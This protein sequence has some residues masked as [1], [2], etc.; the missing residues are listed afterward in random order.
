MKSF[1]DLYNEFNNDEEINRIG[2]EVLKESSKKRKISLLVC[3]IIAAIDIY[4]LYRLFGNPT[5]NDGIQSIY[6]LVIPTLIINIAAVVFVALIFNK[7]HT[8]FIPIF[9]E[10]VIKKM[11]NNFLDDVKYFPNMGM[12]QDIYKEVKYEYYDRYNSDDY[13]EG[14]LNGKY[15]TELAEIKTEEKKE[16]R[17]EDGHT[18]TVYKTV[19]CGLFEKVFIEKSIKSNLRITMRSGYANKLEMD[20]SEFEKIFNVY[21]SNKIIGM[22]ILTADIM[23][24]IL[25]FLNYTENEFDIYINEDE[26]YFRFHGGKL[27][28]PRF[29]WKKILDE[30]SL[31]SYYNILLFTYNITNKIIKA[32]NDVEI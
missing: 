29:R 18:T 8:E 21:A 30:K 17:D 22:Q 20:S 13:A 2:Q 10:K 25:E 14:N 28:E 3:I 31:R 9:K 11:I 12:P 24:D 19:F 5:K 7:K 27:F 6:M 4:F 32:V 15:Y 26:I 23:N 16:V 1:E